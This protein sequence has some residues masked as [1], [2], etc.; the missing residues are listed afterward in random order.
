MVRNTTIDHKEFFEKAQSIDEVCSE[1]KNIMHKYEILPGQNA[2]I[3]VISCLDDQCSTVTSCIKRKLRDLLST[4]SNSFCNIIHLDEVYEMRLFGGIFL[5]GIKT[6]E[7]L[8]PAVHHIASKDNGK[9]FVFNFTHIGYD[10]ATDTFG[11][12]GRYGH[13]KTSASCGAIKGLYQAIIQNKALPKD[14]DLRR[15]GEYLSEI[16][17]EYA[18]S[19]SEKGADIL[20]LTVLAYK[21]Q[22]S[23]IKG[24]LIELA[25]IDD[26]DI[27]YIGG[28]EIDVS[29]FKDYC[30]NDKFAVLAKFYVG[31]N[32]E[33]RNI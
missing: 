4:T 8:V 27:I 21:K 18:I 33:I 9:L 25:E 31:K 14:H 10:I 2:I 16:V 3:S 13:D 11:E 5:P 22:I 7:S 12:F 15:L 28:V 20:S 1:V 19:P 24:Q 23:W 32:G 6:Y 26:I 29:N 17:Q 30:Y